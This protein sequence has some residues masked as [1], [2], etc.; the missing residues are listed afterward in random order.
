[1]KSYT[2]T[3]SSWITG[4]EYDETTGDLTVLMNGREYTHHGVPPEVVEEFVQAP[5]KGQFY[6]QQIKS[7]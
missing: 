6:N 4:A 2:F 5:S 7:Y 3:D 1:M